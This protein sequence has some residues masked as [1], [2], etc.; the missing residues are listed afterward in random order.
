MTAL[1]PPT[2]TILVP[3]LGQRTHLFDR[4]M[5]VL[6]PQLDN[7]AGRVRVVGW[8][9]HGHPSIGVIRDALV[10]TAP[11]EYVSFIDDDDLVPGYYVDEIVKAIAGRPHHVG[12]KLEYRE[13]G[14]RRTIIDH[15]LVHG[16]WGENARGTFRDVTH[17][18]PIRTEL[19]RRARFAV[20]MAGRAEDRPWVQQVRRHLRTE[21][22]VDRVMYHYLFDEQVSAWQRPDLIVRTGQRA[23]VDH[24]YFTWHPECES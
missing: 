17:L 13:N 24:P 1:L 14:D 9:S 22:Y 18:D 19:A 7:H 12:F 15:S 10:Q 8:F 6:L 4:L 21:A 16:R 3:T 5:T 23:D 11:G 20:V 2:W